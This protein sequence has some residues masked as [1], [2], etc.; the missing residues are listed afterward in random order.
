MSAPQI[1]RELVKTGWFM[2][3]MGLSEDVI[4]MVEGK[5]ENG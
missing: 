1:I 3:C 2:S 5:K 4:K